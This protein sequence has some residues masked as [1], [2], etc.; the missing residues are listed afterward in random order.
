MC[1]GGRGDR[2]ASSGFTSGGLRVERAVEATGLAALQPAGIHAALEALE[3]VATPQD[4]QRQALAL[5]LDK[6]RDDAQRARRQDDLADPANRV[7]AGA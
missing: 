1:R 6:A 2:G 4:L 7:V 3:Q 5:A